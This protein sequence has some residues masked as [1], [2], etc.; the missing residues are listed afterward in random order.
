MLNYRVELLDTG[1]GIISLIFKFLGL[2]ESE[3]CMGNNLFW[4][5]C[6]INEQSIYT[7]SNFRLE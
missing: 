3:I 1:V 2:N 4:R 6:K 5:E 7:R